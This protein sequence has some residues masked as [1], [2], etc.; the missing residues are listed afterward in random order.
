MSILR[1][2]KLKANMPKKAAQK[3]QVSR[4]K[5]ADLAMANAEVFCHCAAPLSDD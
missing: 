3:K 2:D 1:F 4:S 5:I